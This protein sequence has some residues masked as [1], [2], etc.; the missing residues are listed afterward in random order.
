MQREAN[1]L[2]RA[3][4]WSEL[5]SL[6]D[7]ELLRTFAVVGTPKEVAEQMMQCYV[8]LVDRISPVIYKPNLELMANL[9]REIHQALVHMMPWTQLVI[10]SL[11]FRLADSFGVT[12]DHLKTVTKANGNLTPTTEALLGGTRADPA[13]LSPERREFILSQGGIGEKD[14]TLAIDACKSNS[15]D[16]RMIEMARELLRPSM[17]VDQG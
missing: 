13:G 4:K 16:T 17:L 2:V 3:G 5:L 6:V 10:G 1:A 8:G 14:L 9:R 7:D 15:I 11:T 12:F